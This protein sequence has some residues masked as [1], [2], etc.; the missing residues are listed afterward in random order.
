[1]K[2]IFA[3]LLGLL[4]S[5][6]PVVAVTQYYGYPQNAEPMT[7]SSGNSPNT[8]ISLT[9][10]G[11][12]GWWTYVDALY[13]QYGGATA[14]GEVTATLA[15]VKGI[16]G[17]A[18][19]LNIVFIVPAGANVF[20]PTIKADFNPAIPANAA[21][22]AITLLVPALGAGNLYSACFLHGFQIPYAG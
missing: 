19:T 5:A 20:A 18:A 15:S 21:G 1:M 2:S 16:G 3:A 11:T 9:L 6:A 8:A 13:C 4:L 22:N 12:P 17:A 7:A 14:A 10:T